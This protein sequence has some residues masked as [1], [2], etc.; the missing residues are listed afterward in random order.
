MNTVLK[1]KYWIG[2]AVC[3]IA[4][5]LVIGAMRPK[6]VSGAQP[7]GS[8]DVE[9]VQ[10]EQKDIPIYGEWIGTLDGFTNA[11]VR[12]QVTGYLVRQGYQEGAFVKKGQLLFEID[13]RPFQAAL[14]QARGQLAQA[15]AQLANAKAVQRRT[16]L[17]V[18]RY[19]PLAKE[20]AASQQDLDNAIQNDLAAK[21][22]VETAAAQIQTAEAAVETTRIN[23]DF[24][25]LVAPI[26]G[27]A[28]QAQLQVGALVNPS[29]GP[30]TSVSTVDPI[31]VY[32]T[33]SEPQYLAWRK[34][35]P[36]ETTRE[37]ADK[38]LRLEL[39]LADGSI[40]PNTGTF[41]FADRQ[42]NESTGAIRIAGLFANP[43]NILRP[44]G[45]GKVRAAVRI[46]QDAL[47]VPQRAV[48]ELQ[49]G[50]QVAVVD[51]GNKVTIRA[52]TVGDRVGNEW[53]ISDGLKR[54]ERVVAEGIQKV[55]PGMLVNPKPFAMES[56][57][58]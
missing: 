27:I 40:Y 16:E 17:D 36:T 33:V 25:R 14:D 49:G 13:P 8:P 34:R 24:T 22:T 5:G 41:Y 21:A 52:V 12:A 43:G 39:I 42:V 15:T 28:G 54:G 51:D 31:K 1:Y 48:S 53:I 26:D 55:R 35:F 11:D 45:Y 46:Q 6:H 38:N 7:G 37:A 4:I 2:G 32:F 50:Y 10:V 30:V 20:Q 9:I 23:L 56:K 47:L 57:E 29:S 18:N 58:K 3:L 19:T 44:G